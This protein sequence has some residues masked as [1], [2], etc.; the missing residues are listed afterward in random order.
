MAGTHSYHINSV[1]QRAVICRAQAGNCPLKTDDGEPMPHFDN[2]A[3]AKQWVERTEAKK[4]ALNGDS[5]KGI[6]KKPKVAVAKDVTEA[7]V[8]QRMTP[9]VAKMREAIK[10]NTKNVVEARSE[11]D[12]VALVGANPERAE[13]RLK[14]SIEFAKSRQNVHLMEKL[15]KSVVLPSGSFRRGDGSR[16]STD[17]MLKNRQVMKNVDAEREKIQKALNSIVAE[18]G[19]EAGAKFTVKT[20]EGTFTATVTSNNFNEKEF[21]KLPED[22]QRKMMRATETIDI[23][24]ARQHVRKEV[25]AGALSKTQV[26]DYVNGKDFNDVPKIHAETNYEG[27]TPQEKM[28]RGVESLAGLYSDTRKAH[29]SSYKDLKAA[30]A[31]MNDSIKKVSNEYY[32]ETGKNTFIPARSQF[33]GAIVTGRENISRKKLAEKMSD[34][35][36]SAISKVTLTPD[37]AKAEKILP[38][39]KFD[40][41]FN[42]PGVTLRATEK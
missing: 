1:T 4:A 30:N 35:E 27:V 36:I 41:I 32:G 39:E 21:T 38:K 7:R 37:R 13:R 6:S 19:L 34:E 2:K 25:L 29:S 11:N 31:E 16:F 40:K 26:I 22:V 20:E 24:L 42:N 8:G 3:S 9:A 15:S 10:Q 33:N 28:Q 12:A 23:D 17:T 14:E 18:G 5:F